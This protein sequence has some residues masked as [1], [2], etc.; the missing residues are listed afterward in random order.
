V[1]VSAPVLERAT[2]AVSGPVRVPANA[3][4]VASVKERV[5]V[6]ESVCVAVS[7]LVKEHRPLTPAASLRAMARASV[8]AQ[9][10]VKVSAPVRALRGATEPGNAREMVSVKDSAVAGRLEERMRKQRAPRMMTAHFAL[11]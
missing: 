2:A 6:T 5:S 7:S 11:K 1:S 9:D 8:K 10:A 3:K 4:A